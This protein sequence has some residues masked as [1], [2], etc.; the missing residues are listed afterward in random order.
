[1]I[2]DNFLNPDTYAALK[3]YSLECEFQ[4][5]VNESDG[6]VY[7]GICKDIPD[8]IKQEVIDKLSEHKGAPIENM[9]MFMRMTKNGTPCPHVAHTDAVMGKH[10]FMLYLH[11]HPYSGTSFLRHVDSGITYHPVHEIFQQVVQ[12]DS[13]DLSK[14]VR[15]GSVSS[16]ENRAAIFDSHLIHC[17]EPVGGFGE[18]QRTARIVLTVFYD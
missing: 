5:E 16:D 12:R 10:S 13:N 2:T 11:K 7:P 18:T 9:T 15:T 1:M 17:A 3:Q 6:V 4:D 14:W 8:D